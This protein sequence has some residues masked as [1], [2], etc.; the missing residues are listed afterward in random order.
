MALS[1]RDRVGQM[2]DAI[3]PPL[4]EFITRIQTREHVTVGWCCDRGRRLLGRG[5]CDAGRRSWRA[6]I[7]KQCPTLGGD[8]RMSPV[9]NE[10]VPDGPRPRSHAANA[11]LSGDVVPDTGDDHVLP[12]ALA[13][14]AGNPDCLARSSTP[15]MG[16]AATLKVGRRP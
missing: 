8:R 5:A 3:A 7:A 16:S 2:F 6:G 10:L 11:L 15:R 4:I 14:E 12:Y 1:N 13:D 9:G